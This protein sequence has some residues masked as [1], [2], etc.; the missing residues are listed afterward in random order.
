[1]AVFLSYHQSYCLFSADNPSEALYIYALPSNLTTTRLNNYGYPDFAGQG[2]EAV[3]SEASVS[4]CTAATEEP[5]LNQTVDSKG[6]LLT[7]RTSLKP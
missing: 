5:D 3:I 4:G 7:L 2:T 1:M 6:A